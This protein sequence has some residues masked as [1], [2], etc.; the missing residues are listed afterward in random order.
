MR[1]SRI[2]NQNAFPLS[3]SLEISEEKHKTLKIKVVIFTII[4][5]DLNQFHAEVE[6]I[7]ATFKG[8]LQIIVQII[9]FLILKKQ[10]YFISDNRKVLFNKQKIL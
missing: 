2:F 1:I 4:S 3:K 7:Q 8:K 6:I 5:I 9:L 10:M